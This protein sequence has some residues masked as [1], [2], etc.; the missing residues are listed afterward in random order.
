[1]APR[2]KRCQSMFGL[3]SY[4]ESWPQSHEDPMRLPGTPSAVQW[5]PQRGGDPPQAHCSQILQSSKH[6]KPKQDY[7]VCKINSAV[8]A[9][10]KHLPFSV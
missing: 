6:I 2:M 8:F 7:C 5:D 3:A 1:M 9:E 4:L 10:E